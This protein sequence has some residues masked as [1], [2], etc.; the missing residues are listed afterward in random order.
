ML[1]STSLLGA[2]KVELFYAACRPLWKNGKKNIGRNRACTHLL[3]IQ[4]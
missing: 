4:R 2:C 1:A 3:M